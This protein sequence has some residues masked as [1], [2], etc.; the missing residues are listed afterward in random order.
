MWTNTAAEA[1]RL[2]K[3]LELRYS[4]FSRFVEVHAVG[5][6]AEGHGLLRCWQLSD[7][8]SKGDRPGWKLVRVDPGLELHIT[9]ETSQ[10][11][12]R[13]YKR[14]DPAMARIVAEL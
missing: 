12:R 7:R 10:A 2:G 8:S 14:S 4:G 13:G 3:A 9:D 5:Y 6:S 1:L 11:P